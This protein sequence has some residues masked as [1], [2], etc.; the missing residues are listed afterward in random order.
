MSKKFIDIEKAI[1]SKNPTLLKWMPGFVLSYIKKVTHETWM[2]EVLG[3]I[4][5]LK[6]IDFVNGII[7]EF[8]LEVELIGEE[9]IPKEGGVI[10]AA[11]HP[12]GGMDGIALMYA[13]GKIRPDIRFLVNDLLMA[14]E[15]FEPLFV[16]VNKLGRNSQDTLA[17]IEEAYA[18]NF[19][20]LVFPAGLVSRKS[21]TGIRD[22]Q[23]KKSF[24]TKAKKYKKDILLCFIEGKNS[25]FFYNLADW[26]KKLGVK[27]NVEMFYLVDEMYKQRGQKVKIRIGEQIAFESLTNENSD[28]KWAEILK[29][30]VYEFGSKNG[31]RS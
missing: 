22:L 12:L 28:A 11:N 15:N 26:R 31:K 30:K 3:R 25:N 14:F 24:I 5:H 4:N 19:A 23:W 7:E 8:E 29:E 13:L 17:K 21:G 6:G 20:V 27:A 1:H 16:P 10:I 18:D 2:N 9:K